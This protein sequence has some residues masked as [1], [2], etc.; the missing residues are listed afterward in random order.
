[1]SDKQLQREH[2][3]R[4]SAVLAGDARHSLE[5]QW[6]ILS[7]WCRCADA[8]G[9]DP[10][11][12]R[13]P[14]VL[15]QQALKEL[16]EQLHDLIELADTD[17]RNLHGALSDSGFALV[18][19]DRRGRIVSHLAH[20]ST[21]A[22]FRRAGLWLGADWGEL[23][24]GTNGI[25]TCIA[26]ERPVTVHKDEHFLRQNIHLTCSAAPI[27]DARGALLAVLDCSCCTSDD[28]RASQV[29]VRTLL[30][31]TARAIENRLFLRQ[32]RGE[33]VLRFHSEP[34]HVTFAHEALLAI[35]QDDRVL[36]VNQAGLDLLGAGDRQALVGQASQDLF[37]RALDALLHGAR[38]GDTSVRTFRDP[39]TGHAFHGFV[40]HRPVPFGGQRGLSI[41]PN[42]RDPDACR[43]DLCT[44]ATLSGNDP[45]MRAAA[46]RA[47]RVMDKDIPILLQGETGTG[48]ELFAHAIHL[49]S[50]RRDKP[51][52]ALNCAA[53]PETLI[54]S[55]LFGY[56]G[57]AFTGARREG[58]RG[59]II[60]SSGGTLFL[61][62]I[63][64][65]PPAMQSRLLR[66]LETREVLPLGAERPVPVD[67]HVITAT[68][69]D[70]PRQVALGEFRDDLFYRINGITLP[71]VPLRERHD[72]ET[73]VLKVLAVENDTG[74]EL[75]LDPQALT[76]LLTYHWPGNLRQLRYVVRT[77]IALSDEGVLRPDDLNLQP[78]PATPAVPDTAAAPLAAAAQAP[79]P[80]APQPGG[81]PLKSAEHQVIASILA[82]HNGNVS[83]TA[84]VLDMSRNTLYRKMRKYGLVQR[85][86]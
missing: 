50:R 59:K 17:L 23:A 53:I 72:L 73:I 64:D 70:L 79:A 42:R 67:L 14:Q 49:A 22:D 33:R 78:P 61:D 62:E 29:F 37:G 21:A 31:T 85:Q 20:D 52:V 71:L 25:G 35:G 57:G 40:Y 55:E 86:G 74:A 3:H 11:A 28:S 48:K 2:A 43:G 38:G 36:A 30:E 7:S 68:H 69:R 80:A 56:R 65:M 83:R 13:L 9:L 24:L 19:T 51:F 54:E 82:A 1:M 46:A 66:V 75:T 47:E 39:R 16:R 5:T 4:I 15:T 26:D 27:R 10:F 32:L 60:E 63:G 76:T 58:A 8:S 6:D 12:A 34:D 81:N 84:E 41:P 18:L 44:L 77:A 45:R